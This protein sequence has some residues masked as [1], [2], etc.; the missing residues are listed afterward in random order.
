MPSS[1][2]VV[3]KKKLKCQPPVPQNVILF[4]NKSCNNDEFILE[5]GRPLI[6]MTGVLIRRENMNT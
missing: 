1:L 3:K 6:N 5:W 2:P 4:G